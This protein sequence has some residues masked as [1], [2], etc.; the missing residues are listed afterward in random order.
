MNINQIKMPE[1]NRQSSKSDVIPPVSP[2]PQ[3]FTGVQ[4]AF[5]KGITDDNILKNF[6]KRLASQIPNCEISKFPVGYFPNDK[7]VQGVSINSVKR[8]LGI[9]YNIKSQAAVYFVSE[10][11]KSSVA[12]TTLTHDEFDNA[13]NIAF[14]ETDRMLQFDGATMTQQSIGKGITSKSIYRAKLIDLSQKLAEKFAN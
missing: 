11:K 4:T 13:V 6:I 3:S 12:I 1:Y 14:E 10:P 9:P 5:I 8:F 2:K 7:F